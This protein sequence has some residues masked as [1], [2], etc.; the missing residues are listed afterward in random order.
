MF[1]YARENARAIT[2][3][4]ALG[5]VVLLT[6]Y[7]AFTSQGA[8]NR[9]VALSEQR[10]SEDACISSVLFSTVQALNQR[11]QFTTAQS[12]ANADLQRSQADFIHVILDPAHTDAQ[13]S[14][15]LG[16]YAD[17]LHKFIRLV[18]KNTDKA[19]AFPYPEPQDFSTC[20]ARARGGD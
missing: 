3:G 12:I 16:H 13:A 19:A 17:A 6:A 9:V 7:A 8:S 1:V 4:V 5:V 15:A 18:Q 10:V 20:L 2:N 11:T 14:E